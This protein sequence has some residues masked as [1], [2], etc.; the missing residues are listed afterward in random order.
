[1]FRI[2]EIECNPHMPGAQAERCLERKIR[3][4]PTWLRESDGD[5]SERLEGYQPL[6]ALAAASDCPL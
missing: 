2:V 5:V 6:W 3:V 4:T 1:M